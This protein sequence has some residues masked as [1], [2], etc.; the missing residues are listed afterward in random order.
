MCRSATSQRSFLAGIVHQ[1]APHGLGRC[2]KEVALVLPRLFTLTTD[3]PQI[4]FVYQRGRLQ[5]LARLF[6]GQL[7]SRELP[8]L[9]I[10]QRQQLLR[11]RRIAGRNL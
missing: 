6:L 1:D 4:R 8:Q 5:R 10:Y 9:V 7:G 11:C 2:R 3:Q